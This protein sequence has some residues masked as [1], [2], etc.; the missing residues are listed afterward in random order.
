MAGLRLGILGGAFDP[1]HLGH[2]IL[3][4]C[5]LSQFKLDEVRFMP[6]GD[7]WRKSHREVTAA[8][9][10]LAMVRLAVE[11][12]Q[13]FVVDEREVKR[14]GATYTVDTL[15]ELEAELS[16]DSELYFVM[17]EDAFVDLPN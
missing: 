15:K 7:P 10:R 8:K 3:A 12:N 13:A 5:A 14:S 6:A 9:H 1:P 4:E 2:L 17:G 16:A 11:G